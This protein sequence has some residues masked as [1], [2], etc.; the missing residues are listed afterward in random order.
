ML[1]VGRILVRNFYVPF[2]QPLHFLALL[3]P[4]AL[5]PA[6]GGMFFHL[7]A[8]A[9]GGVDAHWRGHIH[10]MAP[11]ALFLVVAT[12]DGIG[13]LVKASVR[14]GKWRAY[15]LAIAGLGALATTIALAR[16]WMSFLDLKPQIWP[17]ATIER[18][19]EWDLAEQ[20]PVDAVAATDTWASLTIANRRYAYTY[21]ESLRDKL[22]GAGIEALDWILVNR[23][24]R[25][26][27]RAATA[28]SGAEIMGESEDYVLVKLR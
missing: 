20:I 15:L 18:A 9:H 16:P 8:P 21:D 13:M 23:R 2:L 19:P 28:A 14:A 25:K 27:L 11:V 5:L 6:L 4:A 12:I 3:N 24:D 22:P 7:T 1:R 17:L 26:W 10:H